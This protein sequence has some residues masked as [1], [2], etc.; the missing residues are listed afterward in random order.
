MSPWKPRFCLSTLT[1]ASCA[2]LLGLL[3]A[4]H[5]V[6]RALAE[7]KARWSATWTAS[8][9]AILAAEAG[10]EPGVPTTLADQTVR[11]TLH[12]SVG[13]RAVRIVVS[14]AHGKAP[15]VIGEA[16]VARTDAGPTIVPSSD[17]PLT[18]GGET[19]VVI[20]PGAPA[21]SDPVEL[22]VP[23]LSDL[24]VSIYVPEATPIDTFHWSG[25]QTGYLAQGN[26]TSA[27]SIAP[28]AT[29]TPRLFVSAVLSAG[30]GSGRVVAA[31][32]DSITD[33]SSASLDLNQRWPDRLGER[34]APHR[35]GAI[36]AGISG[37]QLLKDGMGANAV[38]RF[39]RDVLSQPGVE[40]VIVLIGINDIGGFES[41]TVPTASELIAGYRQ[42]IAQAHSHDI[43]ILGGTITPFEGALE[44][45]VEGYYTP[46]KEQVR[47]LV[48]EWIRTSG[49]F[50]AVVDFDLALRDPEHPTRLNAAF[51]SGDKLHPND[52]GYRAMADA[53]DL[54]SLLRRR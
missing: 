48:N 49:E 40:S 1:R 6:P 27:I 15:L 42:L 35:V 50:D 7:D 37:N 24:S 54:S 41:T 46:E 32:G 44:D 52:A 25:Q 19:R 31:F 45:F 39:E 13:G 5:A 8:P 21:I 28:D 2:A 29:F 51:D 30:G 43:R 9:Q 53:I 34:L 23:A 3:V 36:N 14:N 17:R 20:P 47:T 38:A 10:L 16:R 11:Q 18:F 12:V 26:V 22:A 4:A 33:G